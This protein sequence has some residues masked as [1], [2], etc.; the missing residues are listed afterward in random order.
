MDS[1]VQF[2]VKDLKRKREKKKQQRHAP[3]VKFF[4]LR[5]KYQKMQRSKSV[6]SF[7]KDMPKSL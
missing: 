4:F 6:R 2:T 3:R 5:K 1:S 7:C